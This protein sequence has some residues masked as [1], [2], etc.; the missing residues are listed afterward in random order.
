MANNINLQFSARRNYNRKAL[1]IRDYENML[2]EHP[3]V[4]FLAHNFKP[5]A[6][7]NHPTLCVFNEDEVVN[8]WRA[9]AGCL[10][11]HRWKVYIIILLLL[12]MFL[13]KKK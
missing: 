2:D 8:I 11:G 4:P 7:Q 5:T 9:Q 3:E 12:F 1:M 10:I 6:N 13:K